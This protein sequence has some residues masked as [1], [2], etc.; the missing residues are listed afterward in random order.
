[1][2]NKLVAIYWDKAYF[3]TVVNGSVIPNMELT[4]KRPLQWFV[5][6]LHSDELPLQYVYTT[7]SFHTKTLRNLRTSIQNFSNI[8]DVLRKVQCV[9][10]VQVQNKTIGNLSCTAFTSIN[11]SLAIC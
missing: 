1:M 4:L 11:R 3:N 10:V 9:H 5:C 6:L 7:M 8:Y 2:C